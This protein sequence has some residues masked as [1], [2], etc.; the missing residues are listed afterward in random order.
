MLKHKLEKRWLSTLVLSHKKRYQLCSFTF[1]FLLFSLNTFAQQSENDW[2]LFDKS[3]P[4]ELITTSENELT[5]SNGL[6]QRSFHL[7]PN[8]IC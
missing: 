1:I 8:L 7:S 5:I 2:L 4:A 3:Y 6:V